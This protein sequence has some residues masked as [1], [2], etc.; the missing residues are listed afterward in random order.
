MDV[1]GF[2]T[3]YLDP[4]KQRDTAVPKFY[5]RSVRNESLSKKSGQ[6]V[7]EDREFVRIMVP[8]DKLNVIDTEVSE[9]HVRR[10][11]GWYKS[12]KE[13]KEHKPEGFPITAWAI[14]TPALISTLADMNV[15]TVEQLAGLPETAL[16]RFP[17]IMRI[18][19]LARE[20]LKSKEDA[21]VISRL[22]HAKSELEGRIEMQ[23]ETIN[24]LKARLAAL[25]SAQPAPEVVRRGPG[26]PRKVEA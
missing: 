1:E 23:D 10:W 24:A 20:L 16:P 18:Q 25:E 9:H 3:S 4:A 21:Q 5:V 13:N 17:E 7:Y 15:H 11:P 14:A 6:A 2:D 22:Q 19:G 26:R 12:F 8:G